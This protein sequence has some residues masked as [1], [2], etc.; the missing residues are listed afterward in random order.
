MLNEKWRKMLPYALVLFYIVLVL[1]QLLQTRYMQGNQKIMVQSQPNSGTV[2]FRGAMI[3]GNWYGAAQ[4]I[5]SAEGWVLQ[6]EEDVLTDAEGNAL[7]LR[8]PVGTERALVFN[9]G[10]DEGIVNASV[11]QNVLQWN[12]YSAETVDYGNGFQLPYVHFSN[13]IKL[14]M[15]ALCILALSAVVMLTINVYFRKN[16]HHQDTQQKKNS[17]IEFLRFLIIISVVLHHFFWYSSA[18]YLGVDFFF[19]LSGFFLMSYYTRTAIDG[20]EP[21]LAAVKYTKKRYLRL[22]PYYLL[23]FFLSLGLSVCL[24]E[25]GALD[26]VADAVWELLMLEAFGFTENLLVGPGWYCSALIIAGFLVYFLLA[27]YK[28]TYLYVI[29]PLSL[30]IIFAWMGHNVG[31]LNRWL[32]FDTFISTGTLRGFAEIGLGCI[33]YQIYH[34]L[35]SK[36]WGN[37][38]ISTILELA[39]FSYI[40]YIIFVA[41]PSAK[42]F[43]CVFAMAVLI[44]SLFLGKSLWYELLNNRVS[45]FLGWISIGIYLNHNVL[46]RIPWHEICSYFGL[47]WNVELF[48]Y[49]FVVI[50]FSAISTRF[51]E[52]IVESFR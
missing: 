16:P 30:F 50:A 25:G 3:D 40:V 21:A 36:N 9:I 35:R 34:T 28:K 20:E 17:A 24:W 42:D 44:V 29:A 22:F 38:V 19:L 11:G 1:C 18:G 41:G 15:A 31:N 13:K 43:V 2:T 23:A 6:E 46:A 52:N 37:K 8:L 39:C 51:V 7:E 12:L 26:S 49:L 48:T 33:S 10:P 4:L 45:D 32:Q 14:G 47:N 27:K 5:V